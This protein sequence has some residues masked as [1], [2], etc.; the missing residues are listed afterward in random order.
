MAGK[1]RKATWEPGRLPPDFDPLPPGWTPRECAVCGRLVPRAP[2]GNL[3]DGI[4]RWRSVTPT[5]LVGG[6]T[7]LCLPCADK[8]FGKD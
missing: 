3:V 7:I 2:N 5:R 6:W 8:T 1:A 4:S